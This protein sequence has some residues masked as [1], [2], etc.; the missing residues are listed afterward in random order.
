MSIAE[1][2]QELRKQAGYSQEQVAEIMGLS[3]QA[4]SK[5]ESGQ[6]KPEIDN[7]VKLTEIYDEMRFI[8]VVFCNLFDP[9]SLPQ[10]Y[11]TKRI[12]LLTGRCLMGDTCRFT[13]IVEGYFASQ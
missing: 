5:W 12:Y 9:A 8:K 2:L 4:I 1:R 13:Q 3:R 6:G 10:K 7:I 11:T